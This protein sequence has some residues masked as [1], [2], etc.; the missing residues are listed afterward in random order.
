MWF[1][2]SDWCVCRGDL[3][4]ESA[5]LQQL[6]LHLISAASPWAAAR[7]VHNAR[8]ALV[9]VHKRHVQG[10]VFGRSA[11]LQR[12][13]STVQCAHVV[14]MRQRVR[15]W[16][17]QMGMASGTGAGGPEPDLESLS[18]RQLA[19]FLEDEYAGVLTA[20]TLAQG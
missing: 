10:E 19:V 3:P 16:A 4:T 1:D 11:A 14:G 13:C 2:L 18:E 8:A 20:H 5:L 7:S 17:L 12:L 9:D 6:H 15:K